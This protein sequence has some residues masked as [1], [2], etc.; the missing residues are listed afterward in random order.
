MLDRVE[1]SFDSEAQK[2]HINIRLNQHWEWEWAK[3]ITARARVLSRVGL[4]TISF[5][6][7]MSVRGREGNEE[8]EEK[9]KEKID[10]WQVLIH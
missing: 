8:E 10:E 5:T 3:I 1:Q 4:R 6:L 2:G 9:N 7:N